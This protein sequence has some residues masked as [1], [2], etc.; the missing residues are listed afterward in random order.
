LPKLVRDGFT[1]R[2][3]CTQATT[4][5]AKI[6]LLD[7]AKIQEEDAEHK[8]NRHKKQGRKGPYPEIP[9]YTTED[10]EAC[11][12]YFKPVPHRKVV[13][14]GNEVEVMFYDAGHIL[15]SSIIR[16]K[17]RQ[18]GQERI[19]LFSG[20]IGRLSL[21]S[22]PPK[23]AESLIAARL[24]SRIKVATANKDIRTSRRVF[25]LVIE[26]RGYISAESNPFRKIKQKKMGPKPDR[27]S[28]KS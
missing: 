18:N 22:V 17:V 5:L 3:Y 24:A 15:G 26:P 25:N 16:A 2:I 12:D 6:I 23:D 1:G 21:K 27:F 9:L 19:I 7:S 10:V 8:R 20:N 4:E 28:K 14:F 11:F 13:N